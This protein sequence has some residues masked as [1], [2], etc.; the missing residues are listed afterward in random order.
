MIILDNRNKIL[1]KIT[2]TTEL[3]PGIHKVRIKTE[4]HVFNGPG[5]YAI[6]GLV[7]TNQERA[8]SVSEYD[9][10]R[11]TV[12]FRNDNPVSDRIAKM[13]VGDS[14]TVETGLGDGFDVEAIPNK[15]VLVADTTGIPQMV[16]L[17]RALLVQGKVCSLVLGYPSKDG[18]YMI[19]T[20][21]NLCNN[22]EILTED[23]S[24]GRKGYAY[25]AVRNADYVCAAG[26]VM[27]LDKLT[28]KAKSG[29]YN[30]DGMSLTKW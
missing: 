30:I 15:A 25:D 26:T 5:Q 21:S 10:K 22:I 9:S 14:V 28:S 20:F 8:Y 18:I 3:V 13:S 19:D 17:L 11:F 29:Q 4:G 27:M 16:S 2:E 23:G 7:D 24:N 1:G 6:V 12:V